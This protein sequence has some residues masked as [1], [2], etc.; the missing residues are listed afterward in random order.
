MDMSDYK[1][2]NIKGYRFILIMIDDF[3]KFIWCMPLKNKTAHTITSD[4]S[5]NLTTKRSSV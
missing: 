3:S 4:F 2:S 1:I 5:N